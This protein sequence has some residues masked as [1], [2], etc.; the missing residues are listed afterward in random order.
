L[1]RRIDR[2]AATWS[3][4]T[5]AWGAPS[6]RLLL[7]ALVAAVGV[8]RHG[9]QGAPRPRLTVIGFGAAHAS[10][11]MPAGWPS[12]AQIRAATRRVPLPPPRP[13]PGPLRCIR[14]PGVSLTISLSDARIVQYSQCQIPPALLP[15]VRALRPL[16]GWPQLAAQ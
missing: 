11:G 9:L 13:L 5:G 3:S 16:G 14:F 15:A 2:K 1:S 7:L 4:P 10:A 8:P 12:A 6:P